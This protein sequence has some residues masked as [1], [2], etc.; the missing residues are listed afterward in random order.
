[1]IAIFIRFKGQKYLKSDHPV[2]KSKLRICPNTGK[3]INRYL[4]NPFCIIRYTNVIIP[5]K[6]NNPQR[7]TI[8]DSQ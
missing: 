1:M 8:A 2:D 3:K 4:Q 5:N 7:H 6:V